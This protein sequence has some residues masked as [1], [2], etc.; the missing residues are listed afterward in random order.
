MGTTFTDTGVAAAST[1]DYRVVA[2]AG[3]VASSPS[4]VQTV[5]TPVGLATPG[6]PTASPASRTNASVTTRTVTVTWSYLNQ[7]QTGFAVY[8]TNVTTGAVAKLVLNTA[9]AGTTSCRITGA[10]AAA[11]ACTTVLPATPATQGTADLYDFTVSALQGAIESLQSAPSNVVTL[12]P[13]KPAAPTSLTVAANGAGTLRIRWQDN[14][15]NE[16]GF[17]VERQVRRRANLAT[18]T[19]TWSAYTTSYLPQQPAVAGVGTLTSVND[20]GLN[21]GACYQ[22]RY[23]V[24]A[25]NEGLNG[26]N[27]TSAWTAYSTPVSAP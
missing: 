10:T 19:G 3:A 22:Y 1:Y 16:L 21:G 7:G 8:R 25:V 23:R 6:T 27:Q 15:Q 11:R 20:A 26:V 2:W 9:T 14:A 12:I 18:C 24:Q 4:N 13:N 17:V 5:T